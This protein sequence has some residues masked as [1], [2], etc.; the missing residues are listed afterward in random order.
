MMKLHLYQSFSPVIVIIS[1]LPSS[2]TLP[3]YKKVLVTKSL[4]DII[5]QHN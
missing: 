2:T 3:L 4:T 5:S 1:F